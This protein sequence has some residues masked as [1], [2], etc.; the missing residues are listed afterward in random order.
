MRYYTRFP[1]DIPHTRAGQLRAPHPSAT[2]THPKVRPF[3]LHALGTPPA[4]ILSQDQ[5][6]H[7]KSFHLRRS[8][9]LMFLMTA[10]RLH[11]CCH[12]SKRQAPTRLRITSQLVRCEGISGSR[13]RIRVS[14]AHRELY[15]TL[16]AAVKV[17]SEPIFVG[18]SAAF[19]RITFPRCRPDGTIW[20]VTRSPL[21]CLP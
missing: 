5:T 18:P 15:S 2:V 21:G 10:H 9:L 6:L 14:G 1:E 13:P 3:D 17:P 19:R 16:G 4:F 7:Q 12:R 11:Q 20:D 8:G